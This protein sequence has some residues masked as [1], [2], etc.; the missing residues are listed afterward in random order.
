[1][2]I[3][4]LSGDRKAF[5]AYLGDHLADQTERGIT[6]Y[7]IHVDNDNATSLR[8][9][10]GEYR[11][12]HGGEEFTIFYSEEGDPVETVHGPQYFQRLAV[13]HSDLAALKGFVSHALTYTRPLDRQKIRVLHSKGQGYWD[14]FNTSY[15]Q[16]IS[17]VLYGQEGGTLITH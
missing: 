11:W 6:R 4:I 13:K 15:A 1:M 3:E 17:Q 7:A 8:P 12:N 14:A 10:I 16:E 2:T 9:S 5:L